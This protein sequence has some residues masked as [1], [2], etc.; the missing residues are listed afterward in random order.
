MPSREK[1]HD[2]ERWDMFRTLFQKFDLGYSCLL[3]EGIFERNE[4]RKGKR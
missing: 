3:A 4:G 1:A 2:E